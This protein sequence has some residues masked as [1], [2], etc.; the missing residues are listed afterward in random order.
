MIDYL[1][2]EAYK[3]IV[4][5]NKSVDTFIEK[6]AAGAKKI[7]KSAEAKGGYSKLTSIHFKSKEPCYKQAASHIGDQDFLEGKITECL[8]KLKSWKT[9]SQHDFQVVMGQLEAYGEV[10]LDVEHPK[11]Y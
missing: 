6:R 10:F 5:P 1:L 8:D 11:T 3:E 7:Q 2:V 4:Q 9:L